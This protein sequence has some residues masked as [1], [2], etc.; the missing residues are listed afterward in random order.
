MSTESKTFIVKFG[1]PLPGLFQVLFPCPL[2]QVQQSPVSSPFPLALRPGTGLKVG[3]VEQIWAAGMDLGLSWQRT[4]HPLGTGISRWLTRGR[5]AL[6]SRSL[7][8]CLSF[9]FWFGLWS[10][11]RV[12]GDGV[13]LET[14]WN[15]DLL[16]HWKRW[17]LHCSWFFSLP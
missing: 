15:T 6:S 5:V 8:F 7:T 11:G 10:L 12:I 17:C 2:M 14:V 1:F 3:Q 13:E 9:S 16:P 4:R